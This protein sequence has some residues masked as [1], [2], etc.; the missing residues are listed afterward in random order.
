MHKPHV[1]LR[2]PEEYLKLH[3]IE[4]MPL[5]KF[6]DVPDKL[7]PVA[8]NP[9]N[10]VRSREDIRAYNI[11][12]PWGL[13]PKHL[14]SMITQN[15]YS[16]ITYVDDQIGQILQTLVQSGL[17]DNTVINFISDHGWSLGEN[18]EYGKFGNFDVK[19]RIPWLIHDPENNPSMKTFAYKDPFQSSKVPSTP[20]KIVHEPVEMLDIFPTLVDLL[21]LPS[22][23]KCQNR[24]QA[25][26]TGAW[27]L[28]AL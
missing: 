14:Q 3:K 1:N 18:G 2:C 23:P 19:T 26:C 17:A 25:L 10:G 13:F 27:M 11:S 7:P 6:R 16:C 28:Q 5:A 9:Y 24:R 8:F 20:D 22:I 15:Y 21:D 12:K 4:D